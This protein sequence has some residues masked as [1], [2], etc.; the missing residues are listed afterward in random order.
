LAGN[1]GM[2]AIQTLAASVEAACKAPRSNDSIATTLHQLREALVPFLKELRAKLPPMPVAV[3]AQLADPQRVSNLLKQLRDLL[4]VD[5]MLAC[6][7]LTDHSA[8][9]RSALGEPYAQIESAVRSFDFELAM[10][11][12]TQTL[13]RAGIDLPTSM[14]QGI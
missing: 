10:Q 14:E 5:D 11:L 8:V 12:L 1:I 7:L 3:Q 4:A 9:F 6:D 2:H 13:S